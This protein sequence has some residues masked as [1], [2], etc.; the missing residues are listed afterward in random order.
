M[1]SVLSKSIAGALLLGVMT[2]ALAQQAP[3]YQEQGQIGNPES[4]RTEEFKADW[5]LGAIGA[6]YAYARGLTGRG[7]RVG[8]FDSGV[9]LN[10]SEFAGKDHRSIRI[11]DML[12]DGTP[13]ANTTALVG[14]DSCFMSDGDTA[15]IEYFHYTDEDRAFVQYLVE[16]GYLYDWVPDYLES[17]AG[18]QYGSHGTHVA[19]SMA[20]N[21]DGVGSHGVAFGANI[22]TSRLF[23]NSY[24]DLMSLLG[25]E[26]ESYSIG[27]GS[28]AVASM[29][30]QMAAQNVRAINHS[31]G[32]SQEPTTIEEMDALYNS[33]GG[34]EYF[35]TYTDASIDHGML[36]VFAAG[37]GDGAIAGVYAT[38]PR[39]VREAEKYWLSVVN[40]NNTGSI[41]GSSS[42]CGQTR[43]WCLAAPGTDITSSVVGGA[44]EGEEIRDE[45]GNFIGLDVTAEHPEY[46][47]ADY[48]GTSM[49]AP[50]VTGALALLMERFPYLDNPQIR[51]VLLTTATD[52]GEAG[53]DDIYGWGLMDLRKAIEGPGQ[54]RVD[55]D[56]AM[57]QH[58]G[59][60]KV[61]EGLAWDDWTNDIGGDGRLTKSG[62]GWLR[63]SGDNSFGGLTVRQGVLEL[64][65]ANALKGDV[66]VDDG[67]LLLDGSLD[68][69]LHV[70]GGRAVINGVQ[71][72]SSWIHARGRLSGSGTLADTTVEGVV[73]PGNSIG[74]LTIN[75]DYTQAAG[76]VY[77][78]EVSVNGA[79]DHLQVSGQAN[80]LGGTVKFLT[81]GQTM[82]LGEHYNLL[83]AGSLS[84]TFAG[85]DDTAFSPFLDFVLSYNGNDAL[86]DVQRGQALASAAQTFNQ[87]V[88]AQAVDGLAIDAPL[89]QAVTQLFPAPAMAAL[90]N[91]SGEQHASLHSMLVD[92][93]RHVRDTALARARAGVGTFAR[94]MDGESESAAWI[95]VQRNGGT[96]RSDGNASEMTYDGNSTLLGYDY[97]F[98]N[99]WR[100]GVLGGAGNNDLN[101]VT[102]GSKGKTQDHYLGAYVGQDWNNFG[103]RL[104]ATQGWHDVSSARSISL[105][106]VQDRP[107]ADYDATSTQAFV[108]GSYGFAAGAWGFE[109]YAQLAQ[110]RVET[111]GFAERGGAA[112]LT[113]ASSE[114]RINLA[115]AGM[116]FNI[117]LK[118]AQQSES[119]L[120]LRGGVGRRHASGDLTSVSS[121]SW[122]GGSVF[123]VHGTPLAQDSTLVELGLGARTSTNSLLEFG[124]SGQLADEVRDHSANVRFSV[125]F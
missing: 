37:N 60:T 75:G 113:V 63:L 74:T 2:P 43:D 34:A 92:N 86:V 110:V 117:D 28:E 80:L 1:R 18:F 65:G 87:Q 12:E 70:N 105:P 5:G 27:P 121:A 10:H 7:I 116:R 71:T 81:T 72:G 64:D 125:K 100:V 98:A 54:I 29:Y 48:T 62:I 24:T 61:W 31:W 93:S 114:Q 16:I 20:A 84:G 90:D 99:G 36:Q 6:E 102:R 124:Y 77:E 123:T 118:G 47:Y 85:V 89:S 17:I 104:G 9:D 115:T 14:P 8:L 103:L 91:L 33:E 94:S 96:L 56:V 41:D 57:N 23:S 50:H 69:K 112:A 76:S 73:A 13:C 44:I 4:W 35:A 68:N 30:E 108:E 101:V 3:G 21:R 119:W 51:D 95:D 106:G 38:L 88:V 25:A 53:V 111:D 67:F 32:L 58:A 83:S 11:A 59:G 39:W 15:A 45:E 122:D 78:A 40:V 42:I 26:G 19:G 82:L 97:R 66:Q 109:P 46:G 120:S 55:T 52:L 49:A 22:T 107:R 79:S